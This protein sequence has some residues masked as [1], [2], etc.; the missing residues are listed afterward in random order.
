MRHLHAMVRR[1][2]VALTPVLEGL[3]VLPIVKHTPVQP[4]GCSD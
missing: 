4:D 3:R 1:S 2:P